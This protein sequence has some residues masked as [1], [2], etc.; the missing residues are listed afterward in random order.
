MTAA[1]E[2]LGTDI[3]EDLTVNLLNKPGKN[4]YPICSAVWAVCY[5]N[6]P[7]S[8]NK[9][10]VDFLSWATHEGQKSAEARVYAPLPK[11]LVGRVE[12]KLKSIQAGQ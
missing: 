2:G 6:Q 1:A 12:Q 11:E 5:Q 9:M 7:A 3:P 8:Q 4:S 10:V